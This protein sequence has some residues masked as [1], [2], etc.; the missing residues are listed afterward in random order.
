M[1]KLSLSKS[2]FIILSAIL[3]FILLISTISI[4]SKFNTE[5]INDK[6]RTE[7]INGQEKLVTVGSQEIFVLLIPT[8]VYTG[9]LILNLLI[10][11]IS[12]KYYRDNFQEITYLK[13]LIIPSFCALF[14]FLFGFLPLILK[15]T[16]IITLSGEEN[17]ILLVG[18]IITFL[19]GLTIITLSSIINGIVRYRKIR[20]C[21]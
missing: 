10:L 2:F 7:N 19:A 21:V 20:L 12:A 9:I 14:F 17:L 13:S 5:R 15:Y 4:L 3:I 11:L 6:I 1:Q 8:T 18:P 16:K